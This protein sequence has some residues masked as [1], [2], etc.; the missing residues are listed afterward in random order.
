MEIRL[1]KS[2][3][4]RSISLDKS[5]REQIV[6]NLNWNQSSQGGKVPVDLDLGCFWEA[7]PQEP[8]ASGVAGWFKSLRKELPPRGCID[9]LQFAHGNGGPK[10]RPSR[11]GCYN[12]APWVWHAGDD[13]VGANAQG[14][15]LLLNSAAGQYL[16]RLVIYAFIYDGAPAWASTDAVIRLEVPRQPPLV[17]ELGKQNARQNFCVLASLE[18]QA[19]GIKVTRHA[20]FHDGHGDASTAYNWQMNFQPGSK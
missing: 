9:G 5:H 11:Q 8:P 13:R 6:I 4:S 3:D 18:F 2:G 14:E 16:H 19:G 17:I 12:Q 20:S 1:E 10:D 7:V 15:N